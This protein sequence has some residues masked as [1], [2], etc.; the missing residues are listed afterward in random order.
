MQIELPLTPQQ[1]Q[2][3]P[4]SEDGQ[5][6][7]AD[8]VA[9]EQASR[10]THHYPQHEQHVPEVDIVSVC[11]IWRQAQAESYNWLRM[12]GCNRNFFPR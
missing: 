2:R 11:L 6:P 1:Y 12:R 3:L 8:R 10:D 9:T 4:E 5:A 7:I